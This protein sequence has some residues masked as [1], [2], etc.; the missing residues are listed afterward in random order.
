MRIRTVITCILWLFTLQCS[1]Q[2]STKHIAQCDQHLQP[3]QLKGQGDFHS[4]QFTGRFR[5]K[6]IFL[7][8][9]P[10]MDGALRLYQRKDGKAISGEFLLDNH[11]HKP[12]LLKY[13]VTFKDSKG[14]V[15]R[16]TGH[17][18]LKQGH[19]RKINFSDILLSQQDINNISTY[20]IVLKKAR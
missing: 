14:M 20:E 6:N 9:N 4:Q 17:L 10:Y 15:A 18:L 12:V 16:T 1:A 11:A 13:Q 8:M 7:S 5:A 2:V 19:K 3:C